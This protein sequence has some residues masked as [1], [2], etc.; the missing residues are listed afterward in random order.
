MK[1]VIAGGS[2]FLGRIVAS[3]FD[4]PKNKIVIL[5][6]G[7]TVS[8]NLNFVHWDGQY[9]GDWTS[10]LEGA[11]VLIN[12][13]GRSV[14]CRYNNRNRSEILHSRLDS[15]RVLGAAMGKISRPPALWIQSSS[16]TF[17]KHSETGVMDEYTGETGDTFSE[18]VCQQWEQAFGQLVLPFTR[19]IILRM[20]IVLGEGSAL[21]RLINLANCGLGGPQGSGR[22]FMSWIHYRDV[23]RIIDWILAHPTV[24]GVL[25]VTAPH[26]VRNSVFMRELRSVLKIPAGI[27]LPKSLLELGAWLI[28]TETELI[29][30]SRKVC[31]QR[32]LDKGFVF[33]FPDLKSAL[34]DLCQPEVRRS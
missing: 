3:H 21:S 1:I 16:A 32:L 22:Q 26:P 29:L 9:L 17:Y 10:S 12:L 15:T 2:G 25:N 31:P 6:R 27:P 11:D 18:Q 19:K 8:G 14:N 20:G 23:L 33:E 34:G 4:T 30:K 5:T 7:R 13:A 24:Q 28:G